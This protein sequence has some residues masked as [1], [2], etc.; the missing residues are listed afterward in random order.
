MCPSNPHSF[1]LHLIVRMWHNSRVTLIF[2]S[3]RWG[4]CWPA[5]QMV[6]SWLH[7]VFCR[8][9]HQWRSTTVPWVC[10]L[11]STQVTCCWVHSISH[12]IALIIQLR[13][14]HRLTISSLWGISIRGIITPLLYITCLSQ[15]DIYVC[16]EVKSTTSHITSSHNFAMASH[17]CGSVN[18]CIIWYL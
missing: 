14:Q 6:T 12:A 5:W 16:Y 3:L 18:K 1:C 7:V 10:H 17:I 2:C 8:H 15:R 4:C 11:W 9:D 13:V